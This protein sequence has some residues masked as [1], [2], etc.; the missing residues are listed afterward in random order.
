MRGIGSADIPV[1]MLTCKLVTLA[2]SFTRLFFSR[3]DLLIITL[4]ESLKY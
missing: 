3:T 1:Y 2:R 4:E